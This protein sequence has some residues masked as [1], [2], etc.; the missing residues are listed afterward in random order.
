MQNNYEPKPLDTSAI[1][2]PEHLMKKR[3]RLARNNHDNWA[4]KRK[5]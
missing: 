2:L 4:D 1:E 5:K 3:K